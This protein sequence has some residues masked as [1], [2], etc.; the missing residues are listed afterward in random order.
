MIQ[1]LPI[2][3]RFSTEIKS[4]DIR[5]PELILMVGLPLSGKSKWAIEFSNKYPQ[6]DYYIIGVELILER[7]KVCYFRSN[8]N[9]Y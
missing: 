4:E 7:M 1:K 8:P 3:E 2:E 6:K 5:K 9:R